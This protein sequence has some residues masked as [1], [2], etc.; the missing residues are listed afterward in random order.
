MTTNPLK[1]SQVVFYMDKI[2]DTICKVVDPAELCSNTHPDPKMVS[3]A[4]GAVMILQKSINKLNTHS[5][6]YNLSKDCV[7]NKSLL[8][9]EEFSVINKLK[10]EFEHNGIHLDETKR[11]KL[12]EIQD[13]LQ[14]LTSTY[15]NNLNNENSLMV[16]TDQHTFE[17]YSRYTET[18]GRVN[19]GKYYITVDDQTAHSILYQSS[20]DHL[21]RIASYAIKTSQD[22]LGMLEMILKYRQELSELLNFPSFSHFNS[23]NRILKSPQDIEYFLKELAATVNKKTMDELNLLSKIKLSHEK[24]WN[25]DSRIYPWDLKYRGKAKNMN[26]SAFRKYFTLQNCLDGITIIFEKLFRIKLEVVDIGLKEGWHQDVKKVVA[27]HPDEGHLGTIYLDLFPRPGKF[28]GSANFPLRL[29]SVHSSGATIALVCSFQPDEGLSSDEVE[30]LF[31]EF[32]HILHNLLSRTQLQHTSGT[33]SYIDFVETPSLLFEYFLSDFEV[34]S[35]FVSHTKTGETI[36]KEM[37]EQHL[38]SKWKFKGTS[39]SYHLY[40]SLLDNAFH[41]G[42]LKKST[43]QVAEEVYYMVHKQHGD[44]VGYA[45]G[46]CLH[47]KFSH[48]IGYPGA[49]YSYLYCDILAGNIWKYCFE[50]NPLSTQAG[51]RYKN[52]ILRHGGAKEPEEM[53][54]AILDNRKIDMGVVIEKKR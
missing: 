23:W 17:A 31:H 5:Q 49:Y 47:S 8:N 35:K 3:A 32:G 1:P 16:Q 45:P 27:T 24:D 26:L 46:S 53:M 14:K 42:P 54:Q 50:S 40:Y 18:P 44:L 13:N 10:I 52:E 15:M 48:F 39:L 34:L 20:D 41:S 4:N 19:G 22:F 43:S 28:S 6:L 37:F 21:R 33:R 25:S 36:S 29:S 11:S 30:T 2:S 51:E 38:E 12:Y 9:P 7:A